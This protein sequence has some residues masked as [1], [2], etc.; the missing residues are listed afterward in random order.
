MFQNIHKSVLLANCV[1]YDKSGGGGT[2]AGLSQAGCGPYSIC[3]TREDKMRN[4]DSA[5]TSFPSPHPYTGGGEGII[6]VFGPFVTLILLFS[7]SL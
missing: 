3:G 4:M 2:R 7:L 6:A 1:Y 5:P